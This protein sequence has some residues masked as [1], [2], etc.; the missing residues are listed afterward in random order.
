MGHVFS[1]E[2]PFDFDPSIFDVFA[3]EPDIDGVDWAEDDPVL[4]AGT[5]TLYVYKHSTRAVELH[6]DDEFEVWVPSLSSVADWQI[7]FAVL[8]RA[9]D[10]FDTVFVTWNDGDVWELSELVEHCDADWQQLQFLADG[11]DLLDRVERDGV[12]VSVAGPLRSV[13]VGP[14]VVNGITSREFTLEEVLI[15]TNYVAGPHLVA[16]A[17]VE[18][19]ENEQRTLTVLG[20]GLRT[21][22]PPAD[23][24]L[25]DTIDADRPPVLIPVAALDGLAQ[26]DVTRLDEGHRLVQAVPDSAWPGVLDAAIQHAIS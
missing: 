13:L 6:L 1:V 24:V 20:P 26:L 10:L 11:R 4:P 5:A 18:P 2:L 25:L 19:G 7:A 16:E 3:L 8:E 17:V 9:T 12:A 23:A 15:R 22:L 21:L 14:H